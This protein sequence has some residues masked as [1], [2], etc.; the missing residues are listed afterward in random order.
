MIIF[1]GIMGEL[2]TVILSVIISV[3]GALDGLLELSKNGFKLDQRTLKEM[4]RIQQEEKKDFFES[5]RDDYF[6]YS[7]C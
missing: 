4:Q 2:T 5:V 1:L 3:K 7:R 6:I